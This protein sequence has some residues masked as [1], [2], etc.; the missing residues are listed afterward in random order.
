MH[1]MKEFNASYYQ[2]YI[3]KT[4]KVDD[5]LLW[6]MLFIEPL[7]RKKRFVLDEMHQKLPCHRP[8]HSL[9]KK[10][11]LNTKWKLTMLVVWIFVFQKYGKFCFKYKVVS[12]STILIFLK[13]GSL[14]VNSLQEIAKYLFMAF[15]VLVHV[16]FAWLLEVHAFLWK[17]LMIHANI[18]D[19][20]QH[21]DS[22]KIDNRQFSFS[23]EI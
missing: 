8:K 6:L 23:P 16:F 22:T 2:N 12:S 18:N 20:S 1:C 17:N 13:S 5:T 21:L 7:F 19:S 11:K 4:S 15:D 3:E 9:G 10:M 14:L